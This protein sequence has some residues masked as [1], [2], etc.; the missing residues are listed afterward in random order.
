M[1]LS[2]IKQYKWNKGTFNIRPTFI[3]N[4]LFPSVDGCPSDAEPG[5]TTV[6]ATPL[7]VCACVSLITQIF[8]QKQKKNNSLWLYNPIHSW[9]FASYCT[10]AKKLT[11]S[12]TELALPEKWLVSLMLTKAKHRSGDIEQHRR[13]ILSVWATDTSTKNTT[14]EQNTIH[15]RLWRMT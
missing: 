10:N 2:F 8:D 1:L 11:P 6:L 3:R 5:G 13:G 4:S 9:S 12:N 7:R 14:G 15:R